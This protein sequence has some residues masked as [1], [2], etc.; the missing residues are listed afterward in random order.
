MFE[1]SDLKI[2]PKKKGSSNGCFPHSNR[3]ISK[4]YIQKKISL[5][6]NR[7]CIPRVLATKA[8]TFINLVLIVK[9]YMVI[10]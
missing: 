2:F 1:Q 9:N 10:N 3:N 7:M 8:S 5:R 6:I 4:V